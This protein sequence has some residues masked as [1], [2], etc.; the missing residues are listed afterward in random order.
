MKRQF[1]Q[2]K[3]TEQTKQISCGFGFLS[4]GMLRRDR[5]RRCDGWLEHSA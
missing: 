2:T 4:E 1:K 5:W 3:Q